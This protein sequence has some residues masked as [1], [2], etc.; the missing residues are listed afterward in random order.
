MSTYLLANIGTRDVQLDSYDDLPP[1]LVNPKSG[2]L[3]PRRAGAYFRQPEQFSRWLPH[4][5]L[6]MIEKALRLIAPKPDASLRIILFAT[7][8]PE[9]VKEFYRDSDTIFFA[10]LIRA[11]LIE[12]YT[13]IGLP[14]KQIEI[15]LTDSN[16][17]D[18]DQMHDFYKKSLP[19]V[20]DR[21]PVP[22]PVYLLIAGGTPQMNTMLLLIGTEI[23]GPGAQ[24]LY[25]SQELDRALNLDTTRLL[26]RQALQRNLDVILKAYAY[27]SALKLLD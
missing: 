5:R 6:P 11:V 8:Q 4:L 26:Y 7:D 15:R 25:V 27:S 20:A 17:G 12:R 1:E 3:I 18:Y 13:Q 2:M 14:K 22:N 24:P 16:P 19:G 9:S 23:F 21:K 10:E